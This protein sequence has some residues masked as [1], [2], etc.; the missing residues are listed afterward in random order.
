MKSIFQLAVALGEVPRGG[1]GREAGKGGPGASPAAAPKR[2]ASLR[3]GHH[4]LCRAIHSRKTIRRPGAR[5]EHAAG[6]REA[7]APTAKAGVKIQ[8]G[9]HRGNDP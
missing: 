5:P 1:A 7:M 2:M 8:A 4:L 9:P 3:T 6:A